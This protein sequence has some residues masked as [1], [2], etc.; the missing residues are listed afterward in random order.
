M[1]TSYDL[2][3]QIMY[4]TS[5]VNDVESILGKIAT[6]AFRFQRVV[7]LELSYY[8]IFLDSRHRIVCAA[9]CDKD[10]FV[11]IKCHGRHDQYFGDSIIAFNDSKL[12]RGESPG[13]KKA[14]EELGSFK[15]RVHN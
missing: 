4:R 12:N 13:L 9:W 2:P 14:L 7:S 11:R 15:L 1:Q 10:S 3:L 8:L 5:E 6:P